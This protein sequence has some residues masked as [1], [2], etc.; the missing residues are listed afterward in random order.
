[1]PL[2]E[3]E[4]RMFD[5]IRHGLIDSDPEFATNVVSIRRRRPVAAGVCFAVGL[6]LLVVGVIATQSLLA[7]GVVVSVLGFLGMVAGVG[8]LV[9]GVPGSRDLP[10]GPRVGRSSVSAD[11]SLSQRMEERLHRRFDQE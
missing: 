8:L 10:A 1:M 6:I 5:E 3:H 4:Q 9:F 7:L 2:S 11:S